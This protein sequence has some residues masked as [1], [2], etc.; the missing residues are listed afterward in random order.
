[1]ARNL[2]TTV[3]MMVAGLSLVLGELG[4]LV[5]VASHAPPTDLDDLGLGA[6]G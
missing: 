1:M 4:C 2:T 3:K 5:V 6:G